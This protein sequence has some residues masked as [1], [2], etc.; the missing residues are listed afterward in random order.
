MAHRADAGMPEV[1]TGHM[2]LAVGHQVRQRLEAKLRV[3]DDDVRHL[4][5]HDNGCEIPIGVVGHRLEK[6]L[7][8]HRRPDR[9][10]DQRVAVWLGLGGIGG[11][12]H[13]A[14]AGPVLDH[15]GLS[16]LVAQRLRNR[17]RGDVGIAAG[18]EQI[19]DRHRPRRPVTLLRRRRLNR[20]ARMKSEKNQS[21]L[22]II[23]H[24]R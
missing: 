6:K 22:R 11:A 17:A 7:I 9:R 4:A 24:R 1:Q 20:R 5:Q 14:G 8:E 23:F 13:A 12:D 15:E 21:R 16:E 3:A 18:A 2:A 19:D 10:G